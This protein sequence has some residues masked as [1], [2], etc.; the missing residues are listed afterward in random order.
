MPI[1]N[2]R[3]FE[4]ALEEA[5]TLLEQC[6]G[7]EGGNARLLQLLG[8][9]EGYRPTFDM[10]EPERSHVSENAGALVS[11]ARALKDRWE[12]RRSRWNSL[13]EDGRGIG[14]TTGV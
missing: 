10:A 11:R 9:I 6:E 13:P 7:R 3:E 5:V 1:T 8:E 4:V 14:P 2:D 12:A